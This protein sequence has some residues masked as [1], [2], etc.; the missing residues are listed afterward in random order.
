LRSGKLPESLINREVLDN[1]R[2]QE[3]LRRLRG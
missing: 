1:P 3:R 2:L